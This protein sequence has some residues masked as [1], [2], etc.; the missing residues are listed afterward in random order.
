MV[1]KSVGFI[2]GVIFSSL[3]MSLNVSAMDVEYATPDEI[4]TL[5]YVGDIQ[6]EKPEPEFD[7]DEVELIAKVVLGEAEGESELGKR[8]VASTILNRVDSDIWPNTV[9][10]VCY[11]SGQFACLHNG[12]CNRVRVTDSIREL[13]REEMSAR[14][15]YSVMY[16]SCGGY[17]NGTPMFKE[18]AHYFS[19]R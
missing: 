5:S 1:K 2:V 6:E 11:Q 18:G 12:R 9:S 3:V 17:H 16:F 10:G 8:L 7:E 4:V 13:V 15:N 19:G 14:S